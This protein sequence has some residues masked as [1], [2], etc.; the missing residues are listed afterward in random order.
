MHELK[1]RANEINETKRR[2]E[3]IQLSNAAINSM[4]EDLRIPRIKQSSNTVFRAKAKWYEYGE[5]SNKY[6]LNLNK[7]YKKQKLT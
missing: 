2:E 6:F 1:I 3:I 7:V 4:E 5:K